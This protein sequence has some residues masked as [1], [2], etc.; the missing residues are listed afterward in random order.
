VQRERARVGGG[1]R[2]DE[3]QRRE[4]PALALPLQQGPDDPHEAALSEE[5]ASAKIRKIEAIGAQRRPRIGARRPRIGRLAPV[6]QSGEHGF[7]GCRRRAPLV[8]ARSRQFEALPLV[9]LD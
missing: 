2:R 5:R 1:S 3:Q 6:R 8:R 7:F 9:R 4:T